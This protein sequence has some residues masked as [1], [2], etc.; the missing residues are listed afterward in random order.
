MAVMGFSI[1]D[2]KADPVNPNRLEAFK[3]SVSAVL[4]A[5]NAVGLPLSEVMLT[6]VRGLLDG[7]GFQSVLLQ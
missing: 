3:A 7:N 2:G 4:M 1:N 5:L 6:E